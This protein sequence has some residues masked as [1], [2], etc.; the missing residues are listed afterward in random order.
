MKSIV[1][2]VGSGV[3]AIPPDK[4]GATE[5]LLWEFSKRKSR[6]TDITVIDNGTP[7]KKGN[8]QY[9][10]AHRFDGK[11]SLRITELIF[12]MRCRKR[13]ID[14]N[15]VS[16]VS[17]VHCHTP[18][19]AL[20]FALLGLP[21]NIKTV[22]T[23]HNPAWTVGSEEIDFPNRV[24]KRIEG[25]VM[26]KFDHVT[27]ET[28]VSLD[29]VEKTAGAGKCSVVTSFLD[30]KTFSSAKKDYIRRRYGSGKNTV[31]FLSKL[32]R[33]KGVD[34]FIRAAGIVVK[35]IPDAKFFIAGPASFEG[36][37]SDVHWRE[38]AKKLE[39]ERNIVFTGTVPEKDLPSIYASADVFC[40]PTQREVFG[41]VVA[42][43]MAAGTAVVTSDIPALKE[44]TEGKAVHVPRGDYRGFADAITYM[45]RNPAVRKKMGKELKMSA[46]RF[47]KSYVMSR[48]EDL[49]MKMVKN[50]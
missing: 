47:D 31:L 35:E 44:V 23:C 30:C 13:I 48:F 41:L 36:D 5:K 37:E 40:L 8:I 39:L 26:R 42:E 12:G 49:Y 4:G 27:A 24:V 18:F 9:V 14:I 38:L 25:Y 3:V 45:L 7:G 21:D 22:Y 46:K 11:F 19:T 6:K 34:T 16:P 33:I 15:K 10:S 28:K 43:A 2:Q 20:T 1:V 32:N 17:V 29:S 50:P